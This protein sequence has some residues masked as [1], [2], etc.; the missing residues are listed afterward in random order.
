MSRNHCEDEITTLDEGQA[1]WFKHCR[2]NRTVRH[3]SKVISM[4]ASIRELFRLRP[5]ESFQM[6][7]SEESLRKWITLMPGD[8]EMVSGEFSNGLS[9][10][11]SR[12]I[13]SSISHITSVADRGV[14]ASKISSSES[15][16]GQPL[17]ILGSPICDHGQRKI[18]SLK[19]NVTDLEGTNSLE[20]GE[21]PIPDE[22]SWRQLCGRLVKLNHAKYRN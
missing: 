4:E 17:S 6:D 5:E 21:L 7:R 9:H 10:Q 18:I 14:V 3:A 22:F 13:S 19:T 16:P 8:L 2:K 15:P 1:E 12:Y 11:T 20:Q